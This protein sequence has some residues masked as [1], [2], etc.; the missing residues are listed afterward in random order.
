MARYAA[1]PVAF[2]CLNGLRR[3]HPIEGAI[4]KAA[5]L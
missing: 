5:G 2:W 1:P 3:I 4:G